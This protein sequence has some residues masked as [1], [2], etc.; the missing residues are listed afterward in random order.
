MAD[1]PT[2]SSALERLLTDRESEFAEWLAAN[3]PGWRST[4]FAVG[5]GTAVLCGSGLYVNRLFAAGLDAEVSNDELARFERRCAEVGVEASVQC[6]SATRPS[7]VRQLRSRGYDED[8]RI[9]LLARRLDGVEPDGESRAFDVLLVD[10]ASFPA[11]QRISAE[12]W[13]HDGDDARRASDAYAAAAHAV[14]MPGLMLAIDPHDDRPVGATS[15]AIHDGV[16]VLGGTSVVPGERGRGVQTEMIRRRLDRARS[17]GAELAVS[18]AEP[19]GASERNLL[20]AGFRR[21]D[22][23]IVLTLSR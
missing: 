5:D 8:D 15:L 13:E 6:V 7:F 4:V 17:L 11:W 2:W 23:A 10:D 21:A 12:G 3:D 22:E 1:E 20:R 16:A 14:D 9:S 18:T 19:E